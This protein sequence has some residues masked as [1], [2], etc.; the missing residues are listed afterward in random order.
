MD[1]SQKTGILIMAGA[2]LEM[3]LF[4][5][6]AARRSYMAVALPVMAAVAAVSALAFWVG[7]TLLTT[8]EEMPEMEGE[9]EGTAV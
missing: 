1:Q 8:E 6:G 3:L 7:W 2:I 4:L 5:Y 9:S